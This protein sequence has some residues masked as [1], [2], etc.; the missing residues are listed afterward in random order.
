MSDL[1]ERIPEPQL[2]DDE[3]Q[4]EAYATTD[5]AEPHQAFVTHFTERFPDFAGGEVMDLGCGPA[6]ITVRFALAYP[7]A[8]ITGVDGAEAMLACGHRLV[9]QR[10]LADRVELRRL[11]LPQPGFPKRRYDAVICNSLL[12]HLDDPAVQW[13]TAAACAAP[14]APIYVMDLYRPETT[15]QAR[16]L[17][18]LHADGAHELLRQDFYNSLLAAYREP[19][20]RAQLADAGLA[21]LSVELVSDRHLIVWGRNSG[22]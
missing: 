17:V 13:R 7:D 8:Q 11:L 6:D 9:R 20:V 16:A 1:D 10:G 21:H 12:H 3:A 5:F 19:E 14:G 4:A 18:D 2:M 22:R 15:A